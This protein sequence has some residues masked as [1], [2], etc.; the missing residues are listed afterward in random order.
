MVFKERKKKK[1]KDKDKSPER[2]MT[3]EEEAVLKKFE[4]NDREI[5][6]MLEDVIDQLDRI[7]LQAENISKQINKQ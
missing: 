4:E 2:A 6:Q 3:A 1:K 5:D 7:K